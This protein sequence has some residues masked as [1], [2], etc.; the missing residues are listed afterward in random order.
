M[1]LVTLPLTGGKCSSF[2]VMSVARQPHS[3]PA[4]QLVAVVHVWLRCCLQY[5]A[6]HSTWLSFI[7][8]LSPSLPQ[9]WFCQG[10]VRLQ[11]FSFGEFVHRHLPQFPVLVVAL[12]SFSSSHVGM[13]CCWS[14][15]AISRSFQHCQL[16]QFSTRRFAHVCHP[17]TLPRSRPAQAHI[18]AC[19]SQPP[20]LA[21]AP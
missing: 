8:F 12:S 18:G 7:C 1:L 21:A 20:P 3:I 19:T 10:A 15:C 6:L 16:S 17:H 13:C 4:T 14:L 5:C 2:S 9:A 11:A